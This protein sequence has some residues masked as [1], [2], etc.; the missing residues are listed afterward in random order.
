M[1]AMQTL[2]EFCTDV[3]VYVVCTSSGRTTSRA[4]AV[5][6]VFYLHK[7]MR[8]M[9]PTAS[10][11][12]IVRIQMARTSIHAVADAQDMPAQPILLWL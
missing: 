1:N 10:L 12:E 3:D 7:L 8:Q 4:S 2:D 6:L 5:F 9:S 11:Q